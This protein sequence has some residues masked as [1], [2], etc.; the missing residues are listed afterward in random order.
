MLQTCIR[1]EIKYNLAPVE[2]KRVRV[3]EKKRRPLI[4]LSTAKLVALLL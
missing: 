4:F 1:L 3:G 2:E